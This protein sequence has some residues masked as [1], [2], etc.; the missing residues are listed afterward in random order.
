MDI[1]LQASLHSICNTVKFK[2]NNGR[3]ENNVEKGV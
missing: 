1:C 2:E 3:S